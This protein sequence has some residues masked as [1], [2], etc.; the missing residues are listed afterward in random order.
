M[1]TFKTLIGKE[2]QLPLED[3]TLREYMIS[4]AN[5]FP[6][7]ARNKDSF[8]W[9][10]IKD[11]KWKNTYDNRN[12]LMTDYFKDGDIVHCGLWVLGSPVHTI[13]FINN[14]VNDEMVHEKECAICMDELLSNTNFAKVLE[15][16]H[17]Y[18]AICIKDLNSCPTCSHAFDEATK[19]H[20]H[21]L[22]R[23]S[24]KNIQSYSGS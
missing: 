21:Y 20:I 10:F 23:C 7:P 4:V 9:S 22:V 24:S 8:Y 18:H 1:L 15:C 16:R 13:C 12:K 17:C 19:H 2:I 3:V 5:A 14:L 6:Q 11:G